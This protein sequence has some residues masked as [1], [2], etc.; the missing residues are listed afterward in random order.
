[1][2]LAEAEGLRW[3]R[4]MN[5]DESRLPVSVRVEKTAA[6]AR[7]YVTGKL[8]AAGAAAAQEAV[9]K[10]AEAAPG[11]RLA[12]DL[13]GVPYLA[14]VGLRLLISTARNLEKRGGRLVIV[15]PT[16]EAAMVLAVAGLEKPLRVCSGETALAKAFG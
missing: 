8:D 9:S 11:G 1:M 15:N 3:G 2:R 10:A 4:G 13:A 12:L 6:H 7:A 16:D 5:H 14:S